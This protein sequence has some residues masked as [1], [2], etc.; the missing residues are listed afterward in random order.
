MK[1]KRA[2]FALK[3]FV[4]ATFISSLLLLVASC[5]ALNSEF[6]LTDPTLPSQVGVSNSPQDTVPIS[7]QLT[8]AAPVV[9]SVVP[10]PWGTLIAAMMN[11]A[12]TGAAA[13]AT[14]HAR[15]SASSSADAAASSASQKTSA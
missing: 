10:A 12:A 9:Q 11:L 8:A 5:S 6:G 13:F 15:A 2:G 3:T 1:N 7:D 14:F 4:G